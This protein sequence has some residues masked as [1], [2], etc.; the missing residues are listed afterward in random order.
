MYSPHQKKY[1]N[2]FLYYLL[3]R[4]YRDEQVVNYSDPQELGSLPKK[5]KVF[6]TRNKYFTFNV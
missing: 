3:I 2:L 1:L 4:S 6:I 5:Q